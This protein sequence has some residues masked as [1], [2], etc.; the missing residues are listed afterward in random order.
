MDQVFDREAL[1]LIAQLRGFVGDE[2]VGRRRGRLP[3]HQREQPLANKVIT[4]RRLRVR[5]RRNRH[6]VNKGRKI[7]KG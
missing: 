4:R 7:E 1:R 5:E 2:G 3:E 6:R